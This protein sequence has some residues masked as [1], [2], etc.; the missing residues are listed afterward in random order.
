V[1]NENRPSANPGSATLL[2]LVVVVAV[3]YFARV[4]LIPL[5]LAVLLA[6][7]LAPL[8]IR[9]R[10]WGLARI[11]SVVFVV[12][13]SFVLI[14]IVGSLMT[15]QLTDL[16]RQLPEYQQNIRQKL[17]SLR[18]S[19]GGVITRVT[20]AVTEITEELIPPPPAPAKVQ[21]GEEKPVPVEIRRQSTSPVQMLGTVVGSVVNGLLMAAIVVVFVIFMLIQREDLR[22]RLI[23]LVG[24]AQLHITTQ[25]LDDAAHRVSR[26]LLA[27]L[28]INVVYGFAIGIGMYFLGVPNP[29]LWGIL[30]A[31]LRY[32]PY[33]GIWIAAAMPAAIT[34]AVE[35]GWM[36]PLFI[37]LIYVGIDVVVYNLLEPLLYGSSTGISPIA[38]LV[39]AVFWTWLWGPVGLLLATPLTVCLV[40]VGRYVPRLEFLSVVLSDEPVLPPATRFYQRMLAMDLE[41]ATDLAEDFLKGKSLEELYDLV[42]IPA[43]SLAEADR[44]R[45][46]LDEAH[47][48]FIIQNTRLLI[49]NVAKRADQLIAG[50]AP[51]KNEVSAEQAA[52]DKDVPDLELKV[53]TIAARDEAD[54]LAA[55]ML[56]QLLNK[57]G[58]GTK[59]IGAGAL[60]SECLEEVSRQKFKVACVS[61]VPPLG[62]VHTRYLCKRLQAEFP[63]L[64]VVAAI[65][66]QGD[67]QLIRRRQ[68]GIPADQMTTSLAQ[69]VAEIISLAATEN[70]HHQSA[71]SDHQP[72]AN[73]R[74]SITTP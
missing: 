33:L 24:A 28:I 57:R 11:P 5:A 39:S 29:G 41:E 60:A 16:A 34:L 22:D 55:L 47:Q 73:D 40:V 38:I 37:L 43:L 44:H 49:E 67:V 71:T 30:A 4:I 8:V 53:I 20:R 56:E 72:V 32:I 31:L 3:L 68:P 61:A 6:F 27:Q 36:K 58:I 65:L 17:H 13:L 9:L 19:G 59:S 66:N 23:R 70:T 35:P 52:A 26:Y 21:P 54:E 62:Y 64:K 51:S 15:T 63:D 18:S 46:S 12:L 14:G 50:D 7:L 69:T 25:A 10:H 42:I 2:T 45:G 1:T 74:S 48:Q